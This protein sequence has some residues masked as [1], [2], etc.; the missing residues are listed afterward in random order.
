MLAGTH[1]DYQA[2]SHST[3]FEMKTRGKYGERVCLEESLSLSSTNHNSMRG[4]DRRHLMRKDAAHSTF[5][6]AWTSVSPH[7]TP[8][9]G[10]GC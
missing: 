7:E 10:L 1:H 6:Y 8:Q 2:R 5:S 9:G 4:N 3:V